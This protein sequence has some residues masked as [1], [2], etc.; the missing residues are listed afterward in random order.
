[1]KIKDGIAFQYVKD[2]T[3]PWGGLLLNTFLPGASDF[4]EACSGSYKAQKN[5]NFID[6]LEGIA[7][8]LYSNNLD[9]ID[10]KKL[11]RKIQNHENNQIIGSILDS[12]FFSKNRKCRLILGI[13]AGV[14]LRI[15]SL[16]YEDMTL[17]IALKDLLD[18]DLQAFKIMYDMQPAASNREQEETCLLSSYSTLQRLIVEKLQNLNI[19]GK[20][21]AW[22]RFGEGLRFQKTSVSDRL[23]EYLKMIEC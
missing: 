23:M 7:I 18:D 16:D 10:I 17:A 9:E 1:M 20:D 13:I 3:K 22:M 11:Q 5:T 6:F 14:C 21:L 15:D 19:V 12:V 4:I 2:S 8:D